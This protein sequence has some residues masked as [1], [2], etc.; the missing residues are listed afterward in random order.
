[1]YIIAN[2]VND[3]A[4][5]TLGEWLTID[6]VSFNGFMLRYSEVKYN[7]ATKPLAAV[8]GDKST[9]GVNDPQT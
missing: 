8:T 3:D 1:M 6:Q 9:N 2:L 4:P 5:L 7:P